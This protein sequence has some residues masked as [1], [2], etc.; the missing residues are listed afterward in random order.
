MVPERSRWVR[1]EWRSGLADF[2]RIGLA[3][4]DL[5]LVAGLDLVEGVVAPGELDLA[6]P[7]AAVLGR[8]VAQVQGR[9]AS[10]ALLRSLRTLAHSSVELHESV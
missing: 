9:L 10:D 3:D 8:N 6:G 4:E 1:P 5:N 7:L 2:G